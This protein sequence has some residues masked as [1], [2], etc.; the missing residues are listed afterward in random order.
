MAVQE[1]WKVIPGNVTI[2][3]PTLCSLRVYS[4]TLLCTESNFTGKRVNQDSV[5]LA[6][7]T[8]A[9]HLLQAKE[10][11]HKSKHAQQ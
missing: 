8:S 6:V 9:E 2:P 10:Y 4:L 7:A 11:R 5:C 1:L 3:S